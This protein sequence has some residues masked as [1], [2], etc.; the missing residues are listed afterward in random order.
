MRNAATLTN[1]LILPAVRT[2]LPQLAALV[3]MLAS[4]SP[5]RGQYI[6]LEDVLAGGDGSG[7]AQT[8]IT[9]LNPQDGSFT[10]SYFEGR[11]AD[12]DGVNP[13][14]VPSSPYIDS[15]FFVGPWVPPFPGADFFNQTLTQSGVWMRFSP[16]D[17]TGTGWNFILKD[18]VG[19]A[20]SPGLKVGGIQDPTSDGLA[21]VQFNTAIGLHSSM[22]VTFDLE[23]LRARHGAAAVGCFSTF[24]G[25]DDCSIGSVNMYAVL[26][27]DASGILTSRARTFGS[28]QGEFLSLEIPADARYLTLASGAGG[29]DNCD[30]A[31][32]AR[33]LITP[34]PCP[35]PTYPWIWQVT[36]IR[37]APE[38]E[39]IAIVGEMF[40]FVG[41]VR[42]GGVNLVNEVAVSPTLR[43]GTTPSL[44]PGFHDLEVLDRNLQ[45]LFTLP[46][47]IE[48]AG[49]PGPLAIVS[50]NPGRVFSSGG[51][52]ITIVASGPHGG[53]V[54]RVGGVPLV[55]A[56]AIDGRTLRGQMAPLPP[57]FYN[58]D[59][60]DGAEVVIATA[61]G[62]LEVVADS[63]IRVTSVA[64]GVVSTLGG[65]EVTMTGTGFSPG[66]VPRIGGLPLEQVE[67]TS[68]TSLRGVTPALSAGF[69]GA[70][71]VAGSL[72]LATLPNAVTAIPPDVPEGMYIGHVRPAR[73]SRGTSRVR[74]V[75]TQLED[76]LVPR[77]GGVALTQVSPVSPCRLEGTVP[78]LPPGFHKAD[79]FRPGFGV[80]AAFEELVE[81]ADPGAPPRPA[82]IVSEAVR[83]DGSTRVF[84]FG[85]DYSQSTVITVGGKPLVD[86]VVISDELIVGRAPALDPAEG[87]GLRDIVAA[88]ERGSS[89]L[90]FGIR[91]VD[92]YGP[93]SFVRDDANASG[94][95][96]LSDA[97]YILGYLFLGNPT[98][99]ACLDAADADANGEV[100]ISDAIGILQFLFLGGGNPPAP[101]PD[102]GLPAT[103]LLGCSSFAVCGVGGGGAS[104]TLYNNVK[105]VE[106]LPAAESDPRIV[107]LASEEGEIVIHDPP[108]GK[109]IQI[110]DIIAGFT[111]IRSD[112]I[113][114]GV[115]Y[116]LKVEQV[117]AGSCLVATGNDKVYR[118]RPAGLGEAIRDGDVRLQQEDV[119]GGKVS[120]SLHTAL[121]C[122]LGPGAG[123]G[124]GVVADQGSGG[125][126]VFFDVDFG[127]FQVL[128][129]RDGDD[130]LKA[131]FYQSKVRYNSG[132]NFGLG[133][134]AG[135]LTRL[136]FFSGLLLESEVEFY[137][138]A[139]LFTQIHKEEKLLHI[140]KG[141]IVFIGPV[142][143]LITAAIA[144]YAG[145][146]LDAGVTMQLDAGT[147]ASYKAGLGFEFD[148]SSIRNISGFELPTVTA[149]P[150][151]PVFDIEGFARVKGYIRPEVKLFGGLLIKA[152]TG[153][154][155]LSTEI[156]GRARVDGHL[157]PPCFRWGF[158]AG[159]K[160]SMRPQ[161]ELF[162]FELFDESFD[163]INEEW[164]DLL[165]GEIG[166]KAPPV[167]KLA[168]WVE[169]TPTGA[170]IHVDATG[171]YDPD[172]GPL[173]FLWD[174]YDNGE[175][176]R[177][178]GSSPSATF[179][180][181]PALTSPC[182]DALCDHSV[183][184]RVTDDERTFTERTA[185]FQTTGSLGAIHET[186]PRLP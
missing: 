60:V 129:W 159:A 51:T 102:C 148:G 70:T 105:L 125:S 164:N 92:P 44:S 36:P 74:F 161:V 175:C 117:I 85:S 113:H 55:N 45:P 179:V 75:G 49:T 149:L 145:V 76:D 2:R 107:E 146:D 21:Y 139:G 162:G 33:P 95:V 181:D 39:S 173:K 1:G 104:A 91:Y 169:T 19:G 12:S 24:W 10:T 114:N 120:R 22:G 3:W 37:V 48:V 8:A 141:T 83:R 68:K 41:A 5:L 126:G 133:I 65:T 58:A 54:P 106:E 78:D 67:V 135:T 156:F 30:H 25:L 27:N 73:V 47:A 174:L 64:P 158:D 14:P 63:E 143:I 72:T 20:S 97:V 124:G 38:G 118:V 154:V 40:Q 96:D 7:N 170:L 66:F 53:A 32:F 137:V 13:A 52:E 183:R 110:G 69:Q 56:Q 26:S 103:S 172:G 160:V 34:L 167:V 16:A 134:G 165:G 131:G 15:V 80:V 157:N 140:H 100:N 29:S 99:I 150:D 168:S 176:L 115:A 50:V 89:S 71:L 93:G 42:V 138:D 123:G 84:V 171:S 185:S 79:L 6:R 43:T 18:R 166:C 101:F 11:Y 31:T 61:P 128:D 17:A 152:L 109:D 62:A 132:V 186:R 59:L 46:R 108:G 136:T 130:Y 9:G 119:F 23:E 122:A 147:A 77:I 94:Q 182:W 180:F 111:P 86:A 98:R 28:N 88:D 112:A 121:K 153:D 35:S 87:L 151:T 142:P 177:D 57:G 81:V 184:V 163:L 116:M 82:Y 90:N 127:A 144:L 178:T 155:H 4:F